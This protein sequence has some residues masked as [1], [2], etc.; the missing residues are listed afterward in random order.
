MT[1]D[2]FLPFKRCQIVAKVVGLLQTLSGV[3]S[4]DDKNT[5]AGLEGKYQDCDVFLVCVKIKSLFA[6]F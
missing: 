3:P 2:N 6:L 1:G 5:V 4:S